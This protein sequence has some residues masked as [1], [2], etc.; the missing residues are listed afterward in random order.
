[1]FLFSCSVKY[2]PTSAESNERMEQEI[3]NW[4]RDEHQ[5]DKNEPLIKPSRFGKI[6][7]GSHKT[8][9]TE[10]KS[11]FLRSVN[12]S[13][14]H[15]ND[16][17]PE[18]LGSS[19][20]ERS[21]KKYKTHIMSH[22][23]TLGAAVDS[24][25][26]CSD[27][28]FFPSPGKDYS[29]HALALKQKSEN[30]TQ[31]FVAIIKSKELDQA[32]VKMGKSEKAGDIKNEH[33]K[34]AENDNGSEID[35]CSPSSCQEVLEISDDRMN[36]SISK[37]YSL[38][39]NVSPCSSSLSVCDED[40]KQDHIDKLQSTEKNLNSTQVYFKFGDSKRLSS[41]K[42]AGNIPLDYLD[43]LIKKYNV[44]IEATK[45]SNCANKISPDLNEMYDN[46][47]NGISENDMQINL[48]PTELLDF[49]TEADQQKRLSDTYIRNT[50]S[51]VKRTID[52]TYVNQDHVDVGYDMLIDSIPLGF[53][54]E[55]S[56]STRPEE[57]K[58]RSVSFL[59]GTKSDVFLTGLRKRERDTTSPIVRHKTDSFNGSE[60]RT[61]IEHGVQKDSILSNLLGCK[62]KQVLVRP[63]LKSTRSEEQNHQ[64][65]K[66][67]RRTSSDASP[68]VKRKTDSNNG[69]MNRSDVM[70][71]DSIP[72][73]LEI[74]QIFSTRAEEQERPFGTYFRKTKCDI[75]L[76]RPTDSTN[77]SIPRTDAT[78]DVHNDSIPSDQF[79][80]EAEQLL[81]RER[82]ISSRPEV[83]T[84]KFGTYFR[85]PKS[86]VFSVGS[87]TRE[88]DNTSPI[89]KRYTDCTNH[90]MDHIDDGY[91]VQKNSI[92]S[93][94]LRFEAKQL[95]IRETATCIQAEEQ[96]HHSGPFFQRTKSDVYSAG[97]RKREPITTSPIV[98]HETDSTKQQLLIV[99]RFDFVPAGP[100][101]RNRDIT[102]PIAKPKT[103]NTHTFEEFDKDQTKALGSAV[104]QKHEPEVPI[105]K[106]ASVSAS[107]SKYEQS[108]KWP[109]AKIHVG[110]TEKCK[111]L[112]TSPR[113]EV[114][115][116]I[117]RP[118]YET[119]S[120]PL[121]Q[122]E[123]SKYGLKPMSRR[124]A[125]QMLNHIY[126]ELHPFV[127]IVEVE[128]DVSKIM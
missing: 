99:P 5:S 126:D 38:M 35:L 90:S 66:F 60:D 128:C 3:I 123:L 96:E 117:S 17:V 124:T 56:F 114:R 101:K 105:Q 40:E 22:P 89:V 77:D 70:Q 111:E 118:N 109:I 97:S 103:D 88:R 112:I 104:Q 113:V 33:P 14:G 20:E 30:F 59:R 108:I 65:S 69:S 25:A 24:V 31:R 92:P 53:E 110:S 29:F 68:I 93:D 72:L 4:E 48:N 119:M 19:T 43:G 47:R 64:I 83:Q 91:D 41:D 15:V 127:E 76:T 39:Y 21:R 44:P 62:A 80:F 36:Y 49:K 55:Q 10:K 125:E 9:N 28:K 2:D 7:S 73:G 74:E 81:I 79:A 84:L 61:N 23:R 16:I 78:Y 51:V 63:T 71:K 75:L 54:A 13:K 82:A 1:M 95:L 26:C 85:A 121:L 98:R 45:Q 34:I 8:I 116:M 122:N 58:D 107:S 6:E 115:P 67:F 32:D 94:Q 50:E 18:E 102:S 42:A 27:Q 12:N 100:S 87:R 11:L 52:S 57:R 86:D 46:S 120:S 106:T 37:D